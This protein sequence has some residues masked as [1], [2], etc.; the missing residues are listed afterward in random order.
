MSTYSRSTCLF[1]IFFTKCGIKIIREQCFS[2]I[3]CSLI[4]RGFI[5]CGTLAEPIYRKLRGPPVLQTLKILIEYFILSYNFKSIHF[6]SGVTSCVPCSV[7]KTSR[8][9]QPGS[10]TSQESPD[11]HSRSSYTIW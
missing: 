3:Q 11:H 10:F 6:C 2:T 5:I 4:I 1:K 7:M 9:A 8:N